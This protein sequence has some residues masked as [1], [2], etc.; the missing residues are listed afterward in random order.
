MREMSL[1]RNR[2]HAI[3]MFFHM[4]SEQCHHLET[5][6]TSLLCS[7]NW[8]HRNVFNEKQDSCHFYVLANG[9]TEISLM[10][11]RNHVT[12]MFFHMASE[13]C[14]HLETG[15]TSLLCLGHFF[16]HS[17]CSI[18]YISLT[19]TVI[20][21]ELLHLFYVLHK[22]FPS[23]KHFRLTLY[24]STTTRYTYDLFLCSHEIMIIN[25]R[26]KFWQVTKW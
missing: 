22:M 2:N 6:I 9:I 25:L 8:H 5:G 13:Q 16:R 3:S 17:F 18:A 12:S 10:R 7:C 23:C 20:L 21:S 11:N 24:Q 26:S 15:I 14:H 4:A 19:T 1:M